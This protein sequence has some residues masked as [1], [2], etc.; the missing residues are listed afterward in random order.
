MGD[1]L[2]A[3]S[4]R[5]K[6]PYFGYAVLA[7]MVLNWRAIF[8]LVMTDGNPAERLEVFDNNSSPVSLFLAPLLVGTLV[9]ASAE[10]IRFFFEWVARNPKQ[11]MEIH[12]LQAEHKRAI[13]KTELEKFRDERFIRKEEDLIARAKRDEQVKEIENNEVKQ[14]LQHELELL[15]RERDN[16]SLVGAVQQEIAQP[17]KSAQ[18]L[19]LIMANQKGRI[20]LGSDNNGQYIR[21]GSFLLNKNEKPRDYSRCKTVLKEL[22]DIGFVMQV[23]SEKLYE[24]TEA[25]WQ[26]SDSLVVQ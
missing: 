20:F 5:I 19:L 24:I 3:V 9:A 22:E 15:R 17:S 4:A 12:H 11:W 6:T 23:G 18:E 8:L 26:F 25:G 14:Q 7:F 16:I 2:D 13:L 10:W 1:V 21:S